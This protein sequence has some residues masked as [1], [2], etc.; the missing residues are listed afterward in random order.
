[1]SGKTVGPTGP[2]VVRVD[3]VVVR[4][5]EDTVVREAEDTVVRE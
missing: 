2:R 5:A 1:M 4:E 3:D